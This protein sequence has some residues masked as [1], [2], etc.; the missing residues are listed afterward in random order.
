MSIEE[1]TETA[2]IL[3]ALKLNELEDLALPVEA[4]REGMYELD[5]LTEEQRKLA[6][7]LKAELDK[8]LAPFKANTIAQQAVIAEAKAA[9]ARR[10]KADDEAQL[11]A[12]AA[13]GKVPAPRELPKGLQ[14]RRKTVLAGVDLDLLDE[15]YLTYVADSDAILAAAEAGE[16][17]AGAT[18]EIEITVQ[19]RR[20]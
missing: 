14:A 6:A 11:A 8:L 10:L 20:S 16:T 5:R 7:P 9:I 13:R 2:E 19:L 12:V 3:A 18:V 4:L 17:V 15:K 1:A